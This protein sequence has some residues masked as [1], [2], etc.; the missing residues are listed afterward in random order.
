MSVRV[1]VKVCA[2]VCAC[3]FVRVLGFLCVCG[4]DVLTLHTSVHFYRDI[5]TAYTII[6]QNS[7][8]LDLSLPCSA[9]FSCVCV[10]LCVREYTDASCE[11][12][13]SSSVSVME[14]R[15]T[16]CARMPCRHHSQVVCVCCPPFLS[17]PFRCVCVCVRF[18]V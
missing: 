18:C 9:I 2:C 16:V 7:Q 11:Y 4:G 5:A 13:L 14:R 10:L 17:F 15:S 12:N 1:F 8:S 3:M 6:E